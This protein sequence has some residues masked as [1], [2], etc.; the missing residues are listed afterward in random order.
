MEK[1]CQR[2][3]EIRGRKKSFLIVSQYSYKNQ[4]TTQHFTELNN[5]SK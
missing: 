4:Q 3:D 5:V 1:L 2:C